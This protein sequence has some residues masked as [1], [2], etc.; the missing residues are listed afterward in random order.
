MAIDIDFWQKL[1]SKENYK[2]KNNKDKRD[3]LF[4]NILN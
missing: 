1:Y 3:L 2:L 4:C